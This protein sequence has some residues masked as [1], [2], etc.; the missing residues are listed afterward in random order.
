MARRI[1]VVRIEDLA[2]IGVNDDG[3]MLAACGICRIC[4][5]ET[6]CEGCG[7]DC[8]GHGASQ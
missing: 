4:H 1:G 7:Q 3:G 8:F 5:E 2:G 6:G